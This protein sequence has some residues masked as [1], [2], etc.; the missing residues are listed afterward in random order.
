MTVKGLKADV[1]VQGRIVVTSEGKE[2]MIVG[3]PDGMAKTWW[4]MDVYTVQ[5]SF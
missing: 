1:D 2:P 5:F 3:P 4:L